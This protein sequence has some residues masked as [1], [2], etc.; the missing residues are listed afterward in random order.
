MPM[1]RI[2]ADS[3]NSGNSHSFNNETPNPGISRAAADLAAGVDR[4]NSNHNNSNHNN[5]N[6]NLSKIV[7]ITRAVG[8]GLAAGGVKPN[9]LRLNN[10]AAT[11]ATGGRDMA[12][13]AT[14]K[15]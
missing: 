1:G 3:L 13:G 4:D 2:I 11:I 9:N 6:H 8:A 12:A 10:Q 7:A 15:Y 14:I 5:S